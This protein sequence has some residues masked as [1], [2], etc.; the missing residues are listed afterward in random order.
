[1]NRRLLMFAACAAFAVAGCA[2][3]A[4]PPAS[5]PEASAPAEPAAPGATVVTSTADMTATA[6]VTFTEA[7]TAVV[8]EEGSATPMDDSNPL[9]VAAAKDL[10]K[11]LGVPMSQI[12]VVSF[13]AVTW[14]DGSAGCPKPG[15]MYP[16]VLTDGSRIVLEVDGVQY[17]YH[18]GS[19]E[20]FLCEKPA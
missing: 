3:I 11:R 15:M 9:V 7:T 17:E 18:S 16:Q 10:S 13:E 14:P 4:A 12:T 1:M 20:P 2:P 6:P 8:V 19:G 5:V